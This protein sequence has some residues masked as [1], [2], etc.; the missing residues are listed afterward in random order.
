MNKFIKKTV[1]TE[2]KINKRNVIEWDKA[3]YVIA[4]LL[5]ILAHRFCCDLANKSFLH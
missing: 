4:Q 2:A 5:F 1:Y 3:K